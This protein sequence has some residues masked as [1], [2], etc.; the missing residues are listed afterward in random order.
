[1][2]FSL[3]Q[4]YCKWSFCIQG[5][6]TETVFLH[7]NLVLFP[8]FGK[9]T[10]FE[11]TIFISQKYM[12]AIFASFTHN[13]QKILLIPNY[14]QM[15]ENIIWTLQNWFR[16]KQELET[17][18]LPQFTAI[19]HKFGVLNFWRNYLHQMCRLLVQRLYEMSL[20][21]K[22]EP[23]SNLVLCFALCINNDVFPILVQPFSPGGHIF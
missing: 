23:T 13:C 14:R 18:F 19:T 7:S 1:M 3:L 8:S 11:K 16:D 2:L 5:C 12:G 20:Y 21:I 17:H 15:H 9:L 10:E 4:I 6:W 22:K